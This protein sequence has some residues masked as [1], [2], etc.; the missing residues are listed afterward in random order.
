MKTLTR[1]VLGVAI[2]A[3]LSAPAF[4]QGLF[5]TLTGI[6]SDPSG[7]VVPGASV[8]LINESSGSVRVTTSDASGYY[9][10]ASVTVGNFTYKLTVEKQGFSTYEATGLSLLGGQ[11]RNVN[12][13]LRVGTTT[14]T[15]EVSGVASAVVPV[16][17]GEKSETLTSLELQKFVQ[18]GTD[19]ASFISIM[20]GFAIQNSTNNMSNY[21]GEVI[22]INAN[23]D[24]GS[25][26]PLNNA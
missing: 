13:T 25:Q 15:V 18:V 17:S 1:L 26:R 21:S 5:S 4:G 19:A 20:P 6:V 16:D 22:G 7:A 9:T 12:V 11:K 3:A 23:G 2:V 14:Q 10:F 8:R 24:A